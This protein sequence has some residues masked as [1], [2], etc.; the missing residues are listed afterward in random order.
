MMNRP[1]KEIISVC[2]L[3]WQVMYDGKRLVPAVRFGA[4]QKI[5]F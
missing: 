3:N 1:L 4:L 5:N 2:R